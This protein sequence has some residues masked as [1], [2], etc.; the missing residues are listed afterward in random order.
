MSNT[1]DSA[2]AVTAALPLAPGSGLHLD[3]GPLRRSYT[4]DELLAFCQKWMKENAKG[5]SQEWY[6]T[7]LG[8]LIDF[9]TDLFDGPNT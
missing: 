8:M 2:N 6:Y 1:P 7:R 9:A 4:R 3:N 5:C